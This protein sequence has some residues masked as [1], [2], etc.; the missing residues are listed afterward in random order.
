MSSRRARLTIGGF[1]ILMS[2]RRS[3]ESVGTGLKTR[4]YSGLAR[5]LGVIFLSG[6]VFACLRNPSSILAST[7][8]TLTTGVLLAGILCAAYHEAPRRYFWLG[9]AVFGLGHQVMAFWLPSSPDRHL[10]ILT[11]HLY[12]LCRAIVISGYPGFERRWWV[13]TQQS[14]D[15]V[16]SCQIVQSFASL[17]IAYVAGRITR[18][19]FV[20]RDDRRSRSEGVS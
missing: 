6:L 5:L 16:V 1:T 7:V 18:F 10:V 14:G 3:A 19:L 8:F 9:F 13:M 11:S 2:I 4:R 12:E 20:Q 15:Y 17:L